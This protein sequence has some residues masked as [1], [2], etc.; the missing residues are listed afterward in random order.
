[1]KRPSQSWKFPPL[2]AVPPF[3]PMPLHAFFFLF[4]S[5]LARVKRKGT[6]QISFE[7]SRVVPCGTLEP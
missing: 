2:S 4:A 3:E 6:A 1:M 7:R 5:L